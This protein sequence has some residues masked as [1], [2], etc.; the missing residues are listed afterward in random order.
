M[1]IT[2]RKNFKPL[3]TEDPII[4]EYVDRNYA[5]QPEKIKQIRTTTDSSWGCTIRLEIEA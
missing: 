5:G 1:L 2:Y 3:L 4:I